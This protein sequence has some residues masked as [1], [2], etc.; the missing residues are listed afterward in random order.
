MLEKSNAHFSA[1]WW[2][3][4]WWLFAMNYAPS[5]HLVLKTASLPQDISLPKFDE[6]PKQANLISTSLVSIKTMIRA[7]WRFLAALVARH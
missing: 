6:D 4:T 3:R 2:V 5:L 1:Y 7:A